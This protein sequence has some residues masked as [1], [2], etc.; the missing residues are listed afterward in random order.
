MPCAPLARGP[1]PGRPLTGV[2]L[3]RSPLARFPALVG[4][5]TR[6]PLARGPLPCGPLPGRPLA[7]V[8]LARVPRFK[9]P[10]TSR[11][12]PGRPLARV[13]ILHLPLAR[14]PALGPVLVAL[15]AEPKA[16]WRERRHR[17]PELGDVGQVGE[18]TVE[19]NRGGRVDDAGADR[20]RIA[21]RDPGRGGLQQRLDLVRG[22]LG[23]LG[24]HQRGCAG[25]H[26]RRHRR[27][28]SLEVVV[29]HDRGL[30]LA[31]DRAAGSADRDEVLARRGDLRLLR[32]PPCRAAR[33]GIGNDVVVHVWGP[34][35]VDRSCRQQP[36]VLARRGDRALVGTAVAGRDH[37]DNAVGPHLTQRPR[38]RIQVGWQRRLRVDRQQH[39]A[40]AE[41]LRR[42]VDELDAREH[43]PQAR[44]AVLAGNL[45]GEEVGL[46]R[47]A[48]VPAARRRSGTGDQAGLERAVAVGVG[49][50]L[51]RR[52]VRGCDDTVG[53]VGDLSHPR[54]DDRD[55]HA[56]A[57]DPVA[58]QVDRPNLMREGGLELVAV[59]RPLHTDQAVR[60]D[61]R[62]RLEQRQ[63][64][65]G[66]A[67]RDPVDDREDVGDLS[68]DRPGQLCGF[69]G[70]PGHDDDL[71]QVAECPD[72]RG[73]GEGEQE[74]EERDPGAAHR[75]RI[76]SDPEGNRPCVHPASLPWL[77]WFGTGAAHTCPELLRTSVRTSANWN[78]SRC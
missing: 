56:V 5:L 34:Q 42:A 13:P 8:P 40:D 43:L 12:L 48:D 10:L 74:R 21:G 2:P 32:T 9:R 4:P 22:E 50:G 73:K 68:A 46:G 71:D 53:E 60:D 18:V 11:P 38:Q 17:I 72:R 23:A 19:G 54:V 65:L 45:D 77:V 7:G 47:D 31:V 51:L 62:A 69:A 28:R 57:G 33:G 27:A 75:A 26:G 14:A 41:A 67:G 36:R 39:H 24:E 44:R 3:A 66:N 64:A 76:R 52:E 61:G 49:V 59:G 70:V 35:V 30:V 6:S 20:V 37:D 63:A 78:E 25:G 15:P 1:L 58:P 16:G 55:R 29:T